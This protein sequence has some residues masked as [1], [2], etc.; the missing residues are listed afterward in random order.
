MSPKSKKRPAME[1]PPIAGVKRPAPG[2][3]LPAF[4]PQPASDS[5]PRPAKRIQS[6]PSSQLERQLQASSKQY[7]TPVPTSST[8]IL[9]S[10]PSN[11]PRANQGLRRAQSTVSERTPLS[12]VPTIALPVTGEPVLMGRSSN[13]S[14]HQLSGNRLIS[15]VHVQ[16]KYM[17]PDTPD[18]PG[19]VEVVCMGWN[20]I[21]VQCLGHAW[22]L[23]KGDSF[24][25]DEASQIM[26]DV[27]GTRV[28]LSWPTPLPNASPS[29]VSD[30]T[31]SLDSSP[32]TLGSSYG[33]TA[34]MGPL[35]RG[36]VPES[37]IS[38]TP[39][40]GQG[41]SSTMLPSDANADDDD[42]EVEPEP[43]AVYEDERSSMVGRE[44]VEPS[45][46][47]QSTQAPSQLTL[48]SF[49]DASQSTAPSEPLDLSDRDEEN[50]PVIMSFGPQGENL[51]PRMA[52]VRA[53][54]S[55]AVIRRAALM[56]IQSPPGPPP[57]GLGLTTTE[58][59]V[60][61]TTEAITTPTGLRLTTTEATVTS[62]ME[63]STREPSMTEPNTTEST[64]TSL[65]NHIVNQLA[66]SRLSSTPL[67]TILNNLPSELKS[68]QSPG[69]TNRNL[70]RD[71]LRTVLEG[72]RCVGSVRREGKDAAGK[73]LETEYY[74]LPDLD[75]DE[76]RKETVV[77]G[78][79][80]PGLRAC[81]KQHKV[82]CPPRSLGE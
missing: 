27:H 4:D 57:T 33:P 49:N 71:E 39:N 73:P 42:E 56:P 72:V 66:F 81:R 41:T 78:L 59:T 46:A 29:G 2:S 63:P 14:H 26:I 7:P 16:A 76:M 18:A 43:V 40:R 65:A 70:S 28:M 45:K 9:S 15:R 32:Q 35:Y 60:T 22:E 12:T 21:K 19:K 36:F 34:R 11:L 17:P 38:P 55:P 5:L 54:E 79:R 8:G 23:G 64:T 25:S 1:L 67:S 69:G 62:T 10:S 51:L 52:A 50:D 48:E 37:P 24:T 68:G 53:G 77:H 31:P 80:K 6:A 58:A 30:A 13:A 44:D 3:L 82:R 20:G 47:T 61:S 75:E 74:Y